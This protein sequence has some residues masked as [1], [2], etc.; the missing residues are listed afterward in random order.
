MNIK[1][2]THDPALPAP[3]MASAGQSPPDSRRHFLKRGALVSGALGLTPWL[4]GALSAPASPCGTGGL[5]IQARYLPAEGPEDLAGGGTLQQLFATA[6]EDWER[7]FRGSRQSWVVHLDYTWEAMAS[8][9]GQHILLQQGG[10]PS[11]EKWGLIKFNTLQP[12]FA[13]PNPRH[14]TAY[15]EPEERF[16]PIESRRGLVN[17]NVARVSLQPRGD[18]VGR[19]DLYT[20][21]L[22]EIGHALGLDEKNSQYHL[23]LRSGG[24]PIR[25]PGPYNGS[26]IPIS[27]DHIGATIFDPIYSYAVM[28]GFLSR[29]QGERQLISAV[30]V[31]VNAQLSQFETPTFNP[32]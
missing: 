12:W 26:I 18:A 23:Q 28:G 17:L 22:H 27:G 13:D 29:Q 15:A 5:K 16:A 9:S 14:S 4:S 32:Y 21:A 19:F 11:R 24:L 3:A 8:N 7:A 6:A 2:A 31:L 25:I 20:I 10:Q 30:D 1:R